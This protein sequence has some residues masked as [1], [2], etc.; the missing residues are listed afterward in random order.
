MR[1][2]PVS[3]PSLAVGILL[4][5]SATP[6]W[7]VTLSPGEPAPEFS[8][9]DIDGNR[10]SLSRFRGKTVLIA[11]W[12]T[13]CSRCEEELSFLRDRFGDRDDVAVLL[14]N[15][16]SEKTVSMNRISE[17]RKKL[18]LR[19][20]IIVD[21]GLVLWDRFGIN[22]LPTSLVIGKNGKV[23]FVEPNFYWASPEKI[24]EAASSEG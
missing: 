18:G 9:P 11:F 12:S 8:L 13:W 20:P 2:R 1:F 14:V 17:I 21:S 15:Q 24:L 5:L 4:L 7:P 16:D 23:L 10:V 6:S 3:L 22:A 19:F